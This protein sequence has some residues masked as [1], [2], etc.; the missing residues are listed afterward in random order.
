MESQ[1]ALLAGPDQ[2][3]ECLG[4]GEVQTF[5]QDPLGLADQLPGVH[6]AG[7]PGP[8]PGRVVRHCPIRGEQQPD[9]LG[10]V[11]E[12]PR[13]WN[14]RRRNA[15]QRPAGAAP[16]GQHR[17]G[18]APIAG[19]TAKDVQAGDRVATVASVTVRHMFHRRRTLVPPSDPAP[20][21]GPTPAAPPRDPFDL[22]AAY[23]RDLRG[24]S[25]AP[26]EGTVTDSDSDS[27]PAPSRSRSQPPT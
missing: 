14:R 6:G 11:A 9:V 25:P 21:V 4:P 26:P 23:G 24:L 27:D 18:E 17:C 2:D 16:P 1:V 19:V 22:L 10:L 5:H 8:D 20:P 12:R 15:R 3:S 13:A 7:K